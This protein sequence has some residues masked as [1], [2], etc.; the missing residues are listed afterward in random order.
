MG[1]HE[2]PRIDG[3]GACF[4]TSGHA[5]NEVFHV[6]ACSK[7]LCSC[8][9]SPD[10]VMDCAWGIKACMAWH[11]ESYL[12]NIFPVNNK[13]TLNQRPLTLTTQGILKDPFFDLIIPVGLFSV[14]ARTTLCVF[15]PYCPQ[16]WPLIPRD[17]GKGRPPHGLRPDSVHCRPGL[18]PCHQREQQH[19][20][21]GYWRGY[22]RCT[23]G[24]ELILL[25]THSITQHHVA[26]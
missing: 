2:R 19:A 16:P 26:T 15:S 4:T 3:E 21:L 14:T 5:M 18:T 1:V 25:S 11:T 22:A 10:N 13:F 17:S 24:T 12:R 20:G 23:K 7:Y 8:N 6:P 9:A